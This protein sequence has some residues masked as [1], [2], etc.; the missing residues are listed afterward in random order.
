MANMFYRCFDCQGQWAG[1]TALVRYEGHYRC[2]KCIGKI[3]AKRGVIE[4]QRL[5]AP[6]SLTAL[7]PEQL[8]K[9]HLPILAKLNSRQVL[10]DEEQE[11]HSAV[12]DEA[13]ARLTA[14]EQRDIAER[15]ELMARRNA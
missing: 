3:V 13:M 11:L 5:P 14:K 2:H 15:A 8:Y 4:E 6:I 9:L 12:L 1:R 7:T 10:T